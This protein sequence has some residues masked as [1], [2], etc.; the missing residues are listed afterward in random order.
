MFDQASEFF[1]FRL[2][3]HEEDHQLKNLI[4]EL[5]FSNKFEDYFTGGKILV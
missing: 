4:Q 3:A 1:E 5:S 2:N